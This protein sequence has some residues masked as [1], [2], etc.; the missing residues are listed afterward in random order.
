MNKKLSSINTYHEV[1]HVTNQYSEITKAII[2]QVTLGIQEG[3]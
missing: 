3:L 2:T 1:D